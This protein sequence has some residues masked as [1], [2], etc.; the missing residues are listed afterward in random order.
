MGRDI[1]NSVAQA[2]TMIDEAE[3]GGSTFHVE[4]VMVGTVTDLIEP[5][6]QSIRLSELRSRGVSSRADWDPQ[7][8]ETGRTGFQ[9]PLR[10]TPDGEYEEYQ[11]WKMTDLTT[12]M[13]QLPSLHGGASAW[14]LQLQTLTSGLR[15][16]LGD[17]KALLARATDHTTMMALMRDTDLATGP[18]ALGLERF[19]TQLWA[20]LRRAYPTERNHSTLS[21]FTINPGEQ[22][23]AYLDRAK[24]TWRTVHEDP[25]DHTATTLS[26]WKEM[27]VNGTQNEV[28]VKLRGTVGLMALP[29]A[30]FNSH[31]HHHITQFN[32]EKGG[33]DTQVQSLQIQ[34]LKLQLKD[35]KRGS[36]LQL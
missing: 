27:V 29:L 17:M 24:T 26:M 7:H 14:L 2:R 6:K 1:R 9:M 23:A 35:A 3:R 8:G 16:C 32:R 13:E 34:L 22:P 36:L 20:E 12:L 25:Y 30:Q 33:A 21:S 4:G 10:P 11:P 5:V 15:L 18:A 31:V 28:R 19:R